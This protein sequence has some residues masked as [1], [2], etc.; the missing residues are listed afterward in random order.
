MAVANGPIE[1]AVVDPLGNRLAVLDEIES[2]SYARGV[3]LVGSGSVTFDASAYPAYLFP[4]DGRLEFWREVA[5]GRRVL[6][7]GTSFL[8]RRRERVRGDDGVLRRTIAGPSAVEI[9][10]RRVCKIK[11]RTTGPTTCEAILKEIVTDEFHDATLP[12]RDITADLVV[13]TTQHIGALISGDYAWGNV[14]DVLNELAAQTLTATA[15]TFFDVVRYDQRRFVFSVFIGQRGA[16]HGSG[17]DSPVTFSAELGTISGESLVDSYESEITDVFGSNGRALA[18]SATRRGRSPIGRRES[19]VDTSAADNAAQA[20]A[21]CAA[22]LNA[23][24]PSRSLAATLV[25]SEP[26]VYGRDWGF[27]DR[28]VAE[29]DGE[30]FDAWANVVEWSVDGS[31]QETVSPKIEAVDAITY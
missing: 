21:D 2:A 12:G 6:D 1:I 30:T 3:G 7:T 8:I 16:D 5:P 22:E 20:A 15:P 18:S 11:Q 27:G 26:A 28:I 29:I 10:T 13:D 25:S 24:R 17:S 9:L 14:L 31:G 23:N 19:Y 4:V